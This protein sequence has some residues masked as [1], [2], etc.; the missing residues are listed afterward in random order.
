[1]LNNRTRGIGGIRGVGFA[2]QPPHEKGVNGPKAHYRLGFFRRTGRSLVPKNKD[3]S[4]SR[5]CPRSSDNPLA[6]RSSQNSVV[7]RSCQTM[8][9]YT[10]TGFGIPHDGGFTLVG[11]ADGQYLMGPD[12]RFFDDILAD[13]DYAPARYLPV[14]VPPQPSCGK[15]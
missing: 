6:R 9:L 1:M 14:H 5:F 12:T 2:G 7:R 4:A 11:D 8:A 15:C 3:R 10:G 13:L